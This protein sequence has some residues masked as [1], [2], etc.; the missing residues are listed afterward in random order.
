MTDTKTHD[1]L[2]AEGQLLLQVFDQTISALRAHTFPRIEIDES[3]GERIYRCPWCENAMSE[4][5]LLAREFTFWN[6]AS[7]EFYNEPTE[8]YAEFDTD[9]RELDEE[10]HDFLLF[11]ASCD[12]P[13]SLPPSWRVDWV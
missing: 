4:N 2:D 7:H 3:T 1:L 10:Y 13:V 9:N 6:T 11:H 8:K 12:R 5:D